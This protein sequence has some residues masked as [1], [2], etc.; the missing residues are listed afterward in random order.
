MTPEDLENIAICKRLDG[1]AWLRIH[2]WGQQTGSLQ[3]WE[4]GIAHTLSGYAANSWQQSPSPK[5]AKHGARI[6]QLARAAEVLGE[7]RD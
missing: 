2:S 4:Y 7:V 5:Q 3:K 6:V 1:P